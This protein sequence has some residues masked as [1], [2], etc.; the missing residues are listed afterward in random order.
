MSTLYVYRNKKENNSW[1]GYIPVMWYHVEGDINI[2]RGVGAYVLCY[3][4]KTERNL[5]YGLIG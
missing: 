1:D 2:L 4:S 5:K 3:Y